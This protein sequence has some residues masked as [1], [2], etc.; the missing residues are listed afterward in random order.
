[1]ASAHL[2][3][4]VSKVLLDPK[5]EISVDPRIVCSH[6]GE[7]EMS[8][9]N[10]VQ[11]DS[12]LTS[13]IWATNDA[14]D[15]L[16]F[17]AAVN[18]RMHVKET[19]PGGYIIGSTP[20]AHITEMFKE[21]R[22]DIIFTFRFICSQYHRGR[23]RIH[24]DPVN[25]ATT[26]DVSNTTLTKIVD[27]GETTE[28]EFR[29]PYVQHRSW[30]Q[31]GVLNDSSK[32]SVTGLITPTL[33]FDNGSLVVRVLNNLS[34]PI[35]VASVTMM[36][37]VRG[38]ENLEFANPREI[39][40]RY[41]PFEPQGLIEDA[42]EDTQQKSTPLTDRYLINYGEAIPSLR[43]L[44]QRASLYQDCSLATLYNQSSTPKLQKFLMLQTRF[45]CHPG[46]D[47]K[48][49][50]TAKGVVT[51]LTTYYYNYCMYTPL[52]WCTQMYVAQRGAIQWHYQLVDRANRTANFSVIRSSHIITTSSVY[53]IGGYADIVDGAL[54]GP[55]T[56]A[57]NFRNQN[58]YSP[59]G[60]VMTD[61]G[62]NP[63]I[64]IEMPMM[65]PTRFNITGP[66]NLINGSSF[67]YSYIDTYDITSDLTSDTSLNGQVYI[68]K[69]VNAGTD[70]SLT[71]FLCTPQ[72]Y[73]SA[74]C[75]D[76]P[77]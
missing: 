14:P 3:E 73:F 7:D 54:S 15:T 9:A 22:G 66:Q 28:V 39:S 24:W 10:I 29:V 30:I 47:Q 69:L 48:A 17:S 62:V 44:L 41:S 6:T 27:I 50:Y 2:S 56:Y 25:C 38:A 26:T 34:A 57:K 33:H 21:W 46:Y 70:F 19:G 18:P 45:P 36:V 40:Y 11:K 16:L 77:V 49:P 72:L 52:A 31:C 71:F 63:S 58:P 60:I 68:R 76:T 5:G 1:L 20:M 13:V 51:P 23:V 42:E 32:H 75:G 37:F 35:D 74:T 64:S 53:L 55:A 59:G 4:P 43:L 65:T 61:T 12:F 8:I 67:D